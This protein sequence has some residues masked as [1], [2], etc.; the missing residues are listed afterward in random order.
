MSGKAVALTRQAPRPLLRAGRISPRIKVG[1]A[2]G[3]AKARRKKISPPRY[4]LHKEYPLLVLALSGN[5]FASQTHF[6][7]FAPANRDK[8]SLFYEKSRLPRNLPTS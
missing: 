7:A 2:A 5:F 8:Y 1:I 6:G 4:A 3:G